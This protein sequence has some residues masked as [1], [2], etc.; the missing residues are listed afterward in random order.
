MIE[1]TAEERRHQRALTLG[2]MAALLE[3]VDRV[4][5]HPDVDGVGQ[6]PAP[7]DYVDRA[8]A[9]LDAVE[10]WEAKRDGVEVEP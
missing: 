2:I 7:E 6:Q 10:V 8:V 4:W 3:A 1:H 9:L 5:S